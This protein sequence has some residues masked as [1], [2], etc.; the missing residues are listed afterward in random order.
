MTFRGWFA[1]D[2]VEF[3]NSS[4]VSAHLGRVTPTSDAEVFGIAHSADLV[5][6]SPNLYELP[7]DTYEITENLWTP[8]PGS[9]RYSPGLMEIGASWREASLCI[10]HYDIPYD[11]SWTGLQGW[12]GDPWYR[13]EL[14]PWYSVEQPESA[15]FGGVWVTQ[16]TGFDSTPVDRTVSQVI[17]HGAVP[18]PHRDTSRTLTFDAVLVACTSA[19]LEYGLKWLNC[20]LRAATS[21]TGSTLKYLSAHPEHSAVD[22]DD[23]VRELRHVVLT[24]APEVSD[25][26]GGRRPNEQATVYLVNWEMTAC[27][28][29]AYL[30]AVDVAV[31]WDEIT[32]VPVNW[33]HDSNC[34]SPDSCLDMPVLFSAD[35]V[36]EEIERVS[37]PPPVCGGCLPVGGLVTRR[38]SLPVSSRPGCGTT[39][40]SLSITNTGAEPLSLQ[41]YWRVCVTDPRC[42][43]NRFPLQVSGLPPGATLHLDGVSGRFW[44]HYENKDR[45]P[46]GMVG[47]PTGAP[48]RPALLDRGEC[49]DFMVATAPDADLDVAIVLHDRE[50]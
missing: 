8:P 7:E 49:W 1:L 2:G 34:A 32:T 10:C 9:H 47:T 13:T 14:A 18:G 5:E 11:D 31:E 50:A 6:V 29:Y 24:K 25:A 4:R 12:L 28:P 43:D 3:A 27:S 33:V 19:G 17:G 41:A 23:L 22:P 20:R 37:A 15:E 40:V 38:F 48:W 16:V 44:V 45:R 30:P 46:V 26:Q 39:A 42:E 35:C 21:L 36:P